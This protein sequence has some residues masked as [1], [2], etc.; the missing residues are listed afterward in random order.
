MSDHL[1]NY[2]QEINQMID[3]MNLHLAS[4][5]QDLMDNTVSTK[6][7]VVLMMIHTEG[8]I[9]TNELA[10]NLDITASA[11][12]QILNR[13]EKNGYVKKTINP[14]NRREILIELDQ[15]GID[16]FSS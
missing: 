12:S 15:S 2:V 8:A 3:E 11:V 5:Y 10:A 6:Q 16:Y 14:E 1:L 13:L 4:E 7:V 9:T